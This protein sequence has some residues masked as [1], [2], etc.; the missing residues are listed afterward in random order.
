MKYGANMLPSLDAI[1]QVPI[2]VFLKTVGYS[3]AV[4]A[5]TIAK[6]IVTPNFPSISSDIAT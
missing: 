4:K 5:Y 1:E 6:A 3:S 2:A